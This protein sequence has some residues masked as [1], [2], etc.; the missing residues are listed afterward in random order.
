MSGNTTDRQEQVDRAADNLGDAADSGGRTL[1]VYA[2]LYL[3]VLFVGM[4]GAAAASVYFG[5]VSPSITVTAEVS[6]GWLLEYL[7]IGLVAL[8]LVFTAAM[9]LLLLPGNFVS[10]TTRAIARIADAYEIPEE[11]RERRGDD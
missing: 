1:R 6:V 11:A 5:F 8:F 4:A 2:A 10:G 9:V 7:A 3:T